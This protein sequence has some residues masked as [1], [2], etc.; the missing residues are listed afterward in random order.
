MPRHQNYSH[1]SYSSGGF[2]ASIIFLVVLVTF[3][4]VILAFRLVALLV[5][6]CRHHY[7]NIILR[8]SLGIAIALFTGSVLLV[9][10]IPP[11]NNTG[12]LVVGII[13]GFLQLLVVSKIVEATSSA[14]FL[15]EKQEK[16]IIEAVFTKPWT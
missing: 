4:I 10:A 14:N 7:D 3:G 16:K 13:G 8:W 1:G 11:P 9:L 12:F 2:E 6:A 5:R 15:Q